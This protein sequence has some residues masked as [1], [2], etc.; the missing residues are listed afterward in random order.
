MT[1]ALNQMLG[2]IRSLVG[3]NRGYRMLQDTSNPDKHWIM[4]DVS[5]DVK[6]SSILEKAGSA[7]QSVITTRCTTS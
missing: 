1:K 5:G 3:W 6:L 2:F 4:F 7:A